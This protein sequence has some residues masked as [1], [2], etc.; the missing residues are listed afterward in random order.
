MQP[1][2][3]IQENEIKDELTLEEKIA[4]FDEK[5]ETI[6]LEPYKKIGKMPLL[7]REEEAEINIKIQEGD[8]KYKEY[9]IIANIR[10][11]IKIASRIDYFKSHFHN[12]DKEDLIQEGV[13]GLIRA[14]E[15]FDHT[16][17]YKFSTYAVHWI[18][19][20]IGRAIDT[21]GK[22][23]KY[24]AHFTAK[25]INFM[26]TNDILSNEL[27]REPTI[28]EIAERMEVTLEMAELLKIER[29]RTFISLDQRNYKNEEDSNFLVDQLEDL[30]AKKPEEEAI[31][32]V[33]K[34]E[35]QDA[36]KI[37]NKKEQD[38]INLRFGL[39]GKEP[40]TLAEVSRTY[41]LTRE[42]ARQIEI[43]ALKKLRQD[44]REKEF[45]P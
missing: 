25:L 7:T 1:E 22:S 29:K 39:N 13:D 45:L 31:K 27:D 43:R 18:E 2:L 33:Q 16:K 36:L 8:K 28:E 24:P 5:L 37:L 35:M 20:K 38:F 40:M 19:Q 23:M 30:N 44:F 42:K 12:F 32:Q 41:G 34:I 11:V 26:R 21:K 15:M 3:Q 4:I 14:V 6:G 9:L 17:G 10:L